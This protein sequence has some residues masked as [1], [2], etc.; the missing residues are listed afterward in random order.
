M[1]SGREQMYLDL[2]SSGKTNKEIAEIM[3]VSLTT[4]KNTFTILFD[5]YGVKNRTELARLVWSKTNE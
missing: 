5:K 2:V 3:N 4:V 1:S